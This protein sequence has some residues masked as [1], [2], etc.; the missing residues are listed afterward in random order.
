[1]VLAGSLANP[2]PK[3]LTR[4]IRAYR[5]LDL[6]DAPPEQPPRV[7]P[8]RAKRLTESEISILVANYRAGSPI[9]ALADK[10]EVNRQTIA[11]H[12]KRQGVMLHVTRMSDEEAEEA[13]RLYA[14]G[15]SM[16]QVGKR[17]GR[18]ASLVYLTLKRR[19]ITARDSH[20]RPRRVG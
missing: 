15:L 6:P 4:A 5:R 13:L 12:L 11:V 7:L 2:S 19:G 10:F 17:L 16:T 20:G 9:T 14:T 18:S 3:P 8:K 1:M